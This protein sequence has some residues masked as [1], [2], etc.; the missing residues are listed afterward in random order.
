MRGEKI[1]HPSRSVTSWIGH[2]LTTQPCTNGGYC[3]TC[4]ENHLRE[5]QVLPDPELDRPRACMTSPHQPYQP[6]TP[7]VRP[8]EFIEMPS[9]W[10]VIWKPCKWWTLKGMQDA[11]GKESECYNP[12]RL[13]GFHH[14]FW[15]IAR[16]CPGGEMF[17]AKNCKKSTEQ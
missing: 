3:Q 16:N 6:G 11:Q 14:D 7:L 1:K 13:A 4:E 15:I 12:V 10:K 17:G 2:L 5:N 9:C 8:S